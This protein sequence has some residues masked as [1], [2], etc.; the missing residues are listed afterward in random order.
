MIPMISA[1]AFNDL[2]KVGGAWNNVSQ[3]ALDKSL[4]SL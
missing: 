3:N 2:K 4:L 1:S